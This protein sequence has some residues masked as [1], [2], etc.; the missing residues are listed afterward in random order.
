MTASPDSKDGGV[1]GVTEREDQADGAQ[2]DPER[3]EDEL[4]DFEHG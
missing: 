2:P 1:G 4:E 3:R